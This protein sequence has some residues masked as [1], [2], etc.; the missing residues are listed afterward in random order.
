MEAPAVTAEAY[1]FVLPGPPGTLTGG[2]VY[3]R[4]MLYT[5]R[6]K[7]RLAC[8]LVLPGNYPE[9]AKEAR[10]GAARMLRELPD[11]AETIV[12]GLGFSP[13]FEAF[14]AEAERLRIYVLVH[15]PLCDETGL[16][17]ATRARLFEREHRALALDHGIIVTSRHTAAR[18]HEGGADA[19]SSRPS[20]GRPQ[21]RRQPQLSERSL[22]RFSQRMGCLGRS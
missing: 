11:G 19:R 3:D 6:A 13:L 17:A 14:A 20:L 12:D 4:S 8:C 7:G 1:Y 15:H 10:H 5:L 22:F 2:F 21:R 18:H 16:A 9:P